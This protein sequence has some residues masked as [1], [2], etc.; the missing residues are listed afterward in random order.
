[1]NRLY[2]LDISLLDIYRMMMRL[3]YYYFF[4]WQPI[5]LMSTI[6][7]FIQH[8]QLLCVIWRPNILAVQYF[9]SNMLSWYYMG[10]FFGSIIAI[11]FMPFGFLAPKEFE[12]IWLS[13]ISILRVHD[14]GFSRNASSSLHL[15]TF[16]LYQIYIFAF[17]Y[18]SL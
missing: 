8:E 18:D 5:F 10:C 6:I 3:S 1:M 11:L 17:P 4:R 15:S 12:I 13:R 14:D 7:K 9:K 2:R 16:F